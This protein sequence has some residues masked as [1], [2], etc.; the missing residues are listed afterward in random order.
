[1]KGLVKLLPHSLTNALAVLFGIYGITFG[2]I[3]SY[4]ISV[5][6]NT[7]FIVCVIG[8][9]YFSVLFNIQKY[10]KTLFTASTV[11]GIVLILL[12]RTEIFNGFLNFLNIIT[13]KISLFS[14]IIKPTVTVELSVLGEIRAYTCFFALIA[15]LFSFLLSLLLIKAHSTVL[16]VIISAGLF[17]VCYIFINNP[18]DFISL[19]SF[20]AFLLSVVLTK[21]LRKS[22]GKRASYMLSL[23]LP[24]T[25]VFALVINGF[26]PQETYN[27]TS[28]ANKLYSL[29]SEILPLTLPKNA[30]ESEYIHSDEPI[31]SYDI[32]ADDISGNNPAHQIKHDAVGL[33]T[34][35][36]NDKTGKSMLR[37]N[38][39]MSG[40]LLLRGFS[41][42]FYSGS[43]WERFDHSVSYQLQVFEPINPFGRLEFTSYATPLTLST[44]AAIG[45]EAA[46]KHRIH[47]EESE[48]IG[49]IIFTP[50]H[51][52]YTNDY[53]ST[54][55]SLILRNEDTPMSTTN[56]S[57]YPS[58]NI[59]ELNLSQ[60]NIPQLITLLEEYYSEKA[61][62]YYTE[63]DEGYKQ[64]LLNRFEAADLTN[65]KNKKELI[66][67]VTNLVK[68]CASYEVYTP[69]TPEGEDYVRYFLTESRE[70][71][72]MHFA[73]TAVLLFRALGVPAR[74]VSGYSINIDSS[75]KDAWLDVTDKDAHAWA[76]VYID[77]IGWVP[78][79]VT[80]GTP[81]GET[82]SSDDSSA[83]STQSS[84][85]SENNS[86]QISPDSSDIDSELSEKGPL[87]EHN[88]ISYWIF[89]LILPLAAAFI[90]IR[91]L[92]ILKKRRKS[93]SQDNTNTAV[94]YAWLYIEQLK[95]YGLEP[96]KSV[97]SVAQKA[98]FSRHIVSA[99]ER[100]TV[101]EYARSTAK[102]IY[103]SL[104]ILKK[105]VFRF[106]KAL[107]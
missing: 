51:F 16:T 102:G 17:S 46:V 15:L 70:G 21:F 49:R 61:H 48:E 5:D 82:S 105:L 13:T 98:V 39:D 95:K 57:F 90:L 55:D 77:K 68:N 76:E 22:G 104:G 12:Y 106:I 103:S 64:F 85:T 79:D 33:N 75:Q 11:I 93:F 53:Y 4:Q 69:P 37:I 107:I 96:D 30:G 45:A 52:L 2:L 6:N 8:S 80:P 43:S 54:N 89:L 63:I 97:Y 83:E 71:Y 65:I 66:D 56:F 78:V 26:F 42:G 34:A 28:I 99:E 7:V 25:L 23:F 3:N 19:L 91:R 100:N 72:C 81:F 60:D 88:T 9:L 41:L 38:T 20:I 86:S 87:P 40:N 73:S 50:Y 44:Y 14:D 47:I 24:I 1:M 94:V 58:G 101:T 32:S 92:F 18:I 36:Q 74:Y 62:I 27:R 67:R 10:K 31:E 84:K 29:F 35:D 59:T